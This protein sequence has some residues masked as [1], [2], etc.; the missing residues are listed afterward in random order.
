M[1]DWRGI[2]GRNVRRLRQSAGLTQEQL[3]FDASIDL[4]YVG[5]I[6]RGRRNPSL[7]VMV[8]IAEALK[9]EPQAL[10][11]RDNG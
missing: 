6:E 4:T 11:D 9:V 10:L 5:G 8:R 2:V 7:L 3:A 1:A